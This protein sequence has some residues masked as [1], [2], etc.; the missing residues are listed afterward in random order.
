MTTIKQTILNEL[1]CRKGAVAICSLVE[2]HGPAVKKALWE[3]RA[4][5]QAW[6]I[7]VSDLSLWTAD[8]L[9]NSIQGD[10]ETFVEVRLP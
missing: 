1:K 9:A 7:A 4:D 5:D 8:E 3:M 6:L 10:C 2:D